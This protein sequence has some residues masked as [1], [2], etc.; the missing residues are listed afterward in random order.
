MGS[1][2]ATL[3]PTDRYG[4]EL[5]YDYLSGDDYVPVAYGG[6]LVMVY[7]PET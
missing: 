1:V 6:P 4:M 3:N 2:K 7:H 5:G